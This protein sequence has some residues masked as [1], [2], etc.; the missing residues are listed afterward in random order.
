MSALNL[1]RAVYVFL[2]ILWPTLTFA[3]ASTFGSTFEGVGF[4]AWMMVVVLSTVAGLTAL[5]NRIGTELNEGSEDGHHLPKLW[6]FVAANLFGSWLTGLFFFLI[7]EYFDVPDFLE[8]AAVIGASYVG[9]RLI[10]RTMEGLV[11]KALDKLSL[12]FGTAPSRQEY[13]P[14]RFRDD[15]DGGPRPGRF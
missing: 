10:E 12:I 4:T 15:D 8:A 11:D 13:R 3:A 9:A 5:L 6:L 2:A 1:L 14:S 7:C